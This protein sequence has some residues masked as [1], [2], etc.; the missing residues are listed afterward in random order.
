MGGCVD[1]MDAEG[2]K[3][4]AA[5]KAG[6]EGHEAERCSRVYGG[7]MLMLMKAARASHGLL[8]REACGVPQRVGIDR[9]ND[10]QG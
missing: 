5:R 8:G 6:T 3:R 10:K 1:L 2:M 4:G 7:W 9:K